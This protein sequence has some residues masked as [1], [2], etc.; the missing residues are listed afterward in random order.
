MMTETTENA[1][2]L[3]AGIT[4]TSRAGGSRRRTNSL[5]SIHT[6][7]C[8]MTA[9]A[10]TLLATLEAE[11]AHETVMGDIWAA[12]PGLLDAPKV[13][14][15]LPPCPTEDDPLTALATDVETYEQEC[16]EHPRAVLYLVTLRNALVTDYN[17]IAKQGQVLNFEA[18]RR[19][20]DAQEI[21]NL[22][23]A[24]WWEPLS[25]L[26]RLVVELLGA[27][28][29]SLPCFG[30]LNDEVLEALRDLSEEPKC[31]GHPPC[32]E[33]LPCVI[34][35]DPSAPAE[36]KQKVAP[37]PKPVQRPARRFLPQDR[38]DATTTGSV[39]SSR[40]L[41]ADQS[42]SPGALIA[43]IWI[44]TFA[45]IFPV[46]IIGRLM[47]FLKVDWRRPPSSGKPPGAK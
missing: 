40:P 13:I 36:A 16:A 42:S 46:A 10:K 47:G 29:A 6:E 34:P 45:V 12:L 7:N 17:N 21:Y 39:A 30:D 43:T 28:P 41:V 38:T 37:A 33:L 23:L 1:A 32:P 5:N 18:C 14:K 19:Q 35:R 11:L 24:H 4:P 20:P 22:W 31:H 26:R 8:P 15:Q 27:S 25:R 3:D 2:P 9:S 44:A